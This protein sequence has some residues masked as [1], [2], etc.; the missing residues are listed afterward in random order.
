MTDLTNGYKTIKNCIV[1]IVQKFHNQ[2]LDFPEILGTGF[3]VSPEGV[4][5][6][7]RHVAD[8]IRQLPKPS[9]Y[10][11]IPA[12]VLLFIEIE[13]DGKKGVGVLNVDID[14]MGDGE[15]WGD[16]STYLGPNPPE[17]SMLLLAVRETPAIAFASDPLKEGEAIGFG[18]FPMGTNALKAP[19]WLHQLSP[20][21]HCGI[22]SAILPHQTATLPHAFILHANTQPGASG[23]PVFRDD[24]TVVGMVYMVLRDRATIG[25]GAD[26]PAFLYY[27]IPTSLT[28]CVPFPILKQ[29]HDIALAK[30][31]IKPRVTLKEYILSRKLTMLGSGESVFT[32]WDE[33]ES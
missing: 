23:S 33:N 5:C 13:K 15:A 19:G 1:A 2:I 28:G 24:G 27:T 11:G 30:L 9:N 8:A 4:V 32:K 14:S 18:G 21:L 20:F 12:C 26:D 16:T 17:V 31:P 3:L 29:V 6:T 22:V 10:S 7:C 25:G